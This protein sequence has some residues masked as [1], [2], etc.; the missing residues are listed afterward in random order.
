MFRLFTETTEFDMV[1]ETQ[2]AAAPQQQSR[3]PMDTTFLDVESLQRY[4]TETG[5]ILPRRI[6]GLTAVQQRHITTEIKRS[7][8]MLLMK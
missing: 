6:T 1:P 2:N 4:V 3:N 7:R 5:K 8:S